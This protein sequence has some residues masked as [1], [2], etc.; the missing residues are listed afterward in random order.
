MYNLTSFCFAGTK[1]RINLVFSVLAQNLA[2]FVGKDDTFC[3]AKEIIVI[4]WQPK[5]LFHP[6]FND[7][8]LFIRSV[9]FRSQYYSKHK[10]TTTY[11]VSW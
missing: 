11:K 10:H 3:C 4:L 9:Y 2:P 7:Q 5:G 8:L 1:I 6:I